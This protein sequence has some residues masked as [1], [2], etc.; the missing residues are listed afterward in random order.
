MTDTQK[1]KEMWQMSAHDKI[2]FRN[3]IVVADYLITRE[4][5]GRFVG[6]AIGSLQLGADVIDL[7]CVIEIVGDHNANDHA[8]RQ[9]ITPVSEAFALQF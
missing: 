4:S 9:T 8:R 2:S 7:T 3:Y 6:P 1:V 5:G